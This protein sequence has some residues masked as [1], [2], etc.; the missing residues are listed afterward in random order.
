M[1]ANFDNFLKAREAII[2]NDSEALKTILK[3]DP[4]IVIIE[5]KQWGAT[6]LHEAVHKGNPDLVFLILLHGADPDKEIK[7]GGFRPLHMAIILEKFDVIPALL[8]G[9]AKVN[10]PGSKSIIEC[11]LKDLWAKKGKE[12]KN[13]EK[14]IIKCLETLII[15]GLN[16][17][18]IDPL[19]G[20]PLDAVAATDFVAFAKTL[21][22]NGADINIRNQ[23]HETP[24]HIA[25]EKG[26]GVMVELLLING[27]NPEVKN[28][29]GL[30]PLQIAIL[31]GNNSILEILLNSKVNVNIQTDKKVVHNN[32][33]IPANATPLVIAELI[34]ESKIA[35]TLKDAGGIY[36]RKGIFSKWKRI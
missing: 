17:N 15:Y 31:N 36:P 25:T 27:A 16:L 4:D 12:A 28:L 32:R 7:I 2:A 18:L 13:I 10:L 11:L 34:G 33:K 24:L 5:N 26:I 30:T 21:I 35:K 1:T 9:N 8:K 29:L 22:L 3:E 20:S 19:H 14:E 23:N 6:L